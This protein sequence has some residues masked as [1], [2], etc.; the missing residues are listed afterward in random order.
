MHLV[1]MTIGHDECHEFEFDTPHFLSSFG[2]ILKQVEIMYAWEMEVGILIEL[3]SVK[4]K[5]K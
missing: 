2:E 1:N 5:R 3:G 4:A